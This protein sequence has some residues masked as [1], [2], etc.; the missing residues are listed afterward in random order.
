MKKKIYRIE[1]KDITSY[2][3]KDVAIVAAYSN[4]GE[5]VSIHQLEGYAKIKKPELPALNKDISIN[6]IGEDCLTID[7]G[8]TNVLVIQE[9][10]IYELDVPTLSRQE[11]QGLLNEQNHELLN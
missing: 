11:A 4:G 7:N 2:I 3:G 8:T 9:V 1:L 6:L 10:E 5:Y